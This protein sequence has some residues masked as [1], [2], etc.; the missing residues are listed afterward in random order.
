MPFNE[1]KSESIDSPI[2]KK[3]MKIR[4]K[5]RSKKMIYQMKNKMK[6]QNIKIRKT[7]RSIRKSKAKNDWNAELRK[8][9]KQNENELKK[10]IRSG[11]N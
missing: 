3:T 11:I 6:N 2:E 10:R 5:S 7:K 9:Q 1:Y 4:R 8:Q